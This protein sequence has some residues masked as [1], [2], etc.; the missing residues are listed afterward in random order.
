MTTKMTQHTVS[1]LTIRLLHEE[2]RLCSF[3][4]TKNLQND[5]IL[6]WYWTGTMSS[7]S[8]NM[9]WIIFKPHQIHSDSSLKCGLFHIYHRRPKKP[10]KSQ[11]CHAAWSLPPSKG[12]GK[13]LFSTPQSPVLN[14]LCHINDWFWGLEP[15]ERAGGRS[16]S[17]WRWREGSGLSRASVPGPWDFLDA[18][19]DDNV[20]IA[21]AW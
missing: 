13:E 18:A 19:G 1:L 15:Q 12:L 14:S 11:C 10:S 7:Y 21:L 3:I 5:R 2:T 4:S 17:A 16:I 9:L 20:T 8:Y 6:W